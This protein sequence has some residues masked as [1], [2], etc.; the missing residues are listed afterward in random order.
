MFFGDVGG[1]FYGLNSAP[2]L[3]A[4]SRRRR[5]HLYCA[6]IGISYIVCEGY[7]RHRSW[8]PMCNTVSVTDTFRSYPDD[9]HVFGAADRRSDVPGPRSASIVTFLEQIFGP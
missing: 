5:Y 9:N 6:S 3:E 7:W 1:S 4:I 2:E 8:R